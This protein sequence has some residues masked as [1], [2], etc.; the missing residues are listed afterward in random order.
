MAA[1][2]PQR[3]R[4]SS[5]SLTAEVRGRATQSAATRVAKP[6]SVLVIRTE[7]QQPIQYRTR[8]QATLSF[9]NTLLRTN[10]FVPLRRVDWGDA[11]QSPYPTLA[12]RNG[13]RHAIVRGLRLGRRV[14][15]EVNGSPHPLALGDDLLG[16]DDEDGVVLNSALLPGSAGSLSVRVRSLAGPARLDALVVFNAD[17]DWADA[18]EKSSIR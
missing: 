6:G 18:G 17:G 13:A 14:D 5:S 10:D 16:T 8:P 11:P 7:F 15:A 3:E 9:P 1:A 4:R 2:A 12:N